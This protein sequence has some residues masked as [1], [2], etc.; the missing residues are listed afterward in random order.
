MADYNQMDDDILEQRNALEQEKELRG[1]LAWQDVINNLHKAAAMAGSIG[2]KTPETLDLSAKNDQRQ[3]MLNQYLEQQKSARDTDRMAKRIELEKAIEAKYAQPKKASY[4]TVNLD[5]KVYSVNKENPND[6]VLLGKAD[7][8]DQKPLFDN[9]SGY[10]AKGTTNPVARTDSGI[11][12]IV[13]NK[14]VSE[15]EPTPQKTPASV[16]QSQ[17]ESE[18]RYN[19]LKKNAA[20][21]KEII[22]KEGTFAPFGTAGSDMD[23]KIYQMA[24]DYAKLVDPDSVA[25]EGEVAAAQ[26]YLLTFRNYGGIGTK[27]STALKQIDNYL[28]DLDKRLEARKMANEGTQIAMP[29]KEPQ[30][31][32]PNTAIAAP[33]TRK[34]KDGKT[35][36]RHSD[37]FYYE[38]PE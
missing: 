13:T 7:K 26:K 8:K 2:G 14:P 1:D 12:D 30:E 37:G 25:R 24:V 21:L 22:K 36:Y 5:G 32:K 19:I 34:T 6:K 15:I 38:Q 3:N 28:S 18:Y 33:I 31:G 27:N 35:V 23:S 9:I 16:A 17:K 20:D 11:I 29:K 10:V 4:E